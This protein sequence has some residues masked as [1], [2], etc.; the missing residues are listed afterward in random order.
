MPDGRVVVFDFAKQGFQVFGP[1][2]AFIESVTL[3][4]ETGFPGSRLE[5]TPD[6]RLVSIGGVR[7]SMAAD[8]HAGPPPGRPIDRYGLDGSRDVA[9]MAWQPPTPEIEDGPELAAGGNRMSFSMPKL[10][11]FEP[12]FQ[13]DV[14][15]DGRLA[16]VDS[17]A[18]RVK[19]VESGVVAG[20]LDR[21]IAP[22]A[23]D[24]EIMDLE[25]ARQREQYSEDGSGGGGAR[26]VVIGRASGGSGGGNVTFGA[27]AMRQMMLD[28]VEGMVFAEEIPVI[29]NLKVDWDGRIWIERNGPLPGEPGPTDIVTPDGSYLGTIAA[30][31]LRIPA[32]FGPDGFV[33]FIEAD[34]LEVQRVRVARLAENEALEGGR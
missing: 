28:R 34:E 1:G 21:P 25:R 33:A 4:P 26:M 32:A 31:G 10:R 15:P 24:A 27:D 12:Q 14:L 13:A 20:T 22:V 3:T 11:A 23:V 18:Y 9:Y 19:I 16:V 8:G 17:V 6:G 29:S 2:G 5:A 30:D 7:F